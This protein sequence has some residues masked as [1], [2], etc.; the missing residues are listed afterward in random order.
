MHLPKPLST[1]EE[2]F[3]AV[4]RENVHNIFKEYVK[5]KCKEDGEQMSNLSPSQMRGLVKL[6]KR[7]KELEIVILLTDK[8]GKLAVT[9]MES[10]L[11]M[12]AVHIQGDREVTVETSRDTQRKLNGHMSMW[13]KISG[14]G[15]NWQHYD[16]MR[17]TT[18]NQSC[19]VAP[20]SLMVKDHKPCAIDEL[21]K[22]RP[23][24]SGSEG[25][26]VHFGNIVSEHLEAIAEARKTTID[27]ISTEDFIN[28]IEGY[29]DEIERYGET[30]KEEA[31]EKGNTDMYRKRVAIV[32]ADAK[33]LYPSCEG[34]HSGRCVREAAMKSQLKVEGW[35]YIEAARYVAIGYDKFETREFGLDRVVPKRRFHKGRN[36]GVTGVEPLSGYIEDEEK[37]I[38]PRVEPTELEKR[39]LVAACLDI[40]VR[41]AFSLHLYQFGGRIYHQK[42]GGPIGMRL[43]GAAAKIVMGEW[44]ER[45]LNIME[46]N[47]VDVHLAAGFVDD[48][49]FLTT[50]IEK[51]WRW[52]M[53][54]KKL[55][56]KESWRTEDEEEDQEDNIRHSRVVQ[57]MMNSIYKNIQFEVEMAEDFVDRKLP[58]LDFKMWLEGEN[59]DG[60]EK[61]ER[62]DCKKRIMYSFYEKPMASPF[63]VMEK[64]ALPENSK[65]AT[66]AQELVRRMMNTSELLTQEERNEVIEKFIIRLKRSGYHE[67][68]IRNIVMS[69]LKG[70]ETKKEKAKLNDEKLHRSA[71]STQAKRH[72]KKVMGKSTW[73]RQKKAAIDGDSVK[74]GKR[75]ASGGIKK[76]ET[77]KTNNNRTP[78]TVLFVPRTPGG[79]LARRIRQS[80]TQM[81]QITGYRVKIVER[82]GVMIK[83]MVVKT[84]PWNDGS[85]G[86]PQCLI[87]RHENGGGDCSKRSVTYRTRCEVCHERNEKKGEA[88]EMIYVGESAR[89]GFERAEEHEADY[90]KA[91]EDSH[92]YKHWLTEHQTEEKPTFSM[93]ILKRHKSAFVRQI[94]EAV[95]IEMHSEKDTILNSKSEYNRC[96]LPRLNVKMGENDFHMERVTVQMTETDIEQAL[97]DN[98]NRKRENDQPEAAHQP[99]SKRRKTRTK[100]PQKMSPKKRTRKEAHSTSRPTKRQKLEAEEEEGISTASI[101]QK[102][103]NCDEI[104]EKEKF[105]NIS[106]PELKNG[107][108]LNENQVP[109]V[110]SLEGGE[111]TEEGNMNIKLYPLF[112]TV[113]KPGKIKEKN[114]RIQAK[115]KAHPTSKSQPDDQPPPPPAP[116]Q[117]KPGNL[118]LRKQ[119]KQVTQPNNKQPNLANYSKITA[120]FKPLTKNMNFSPTDQPLITSDQMK[121]DEPSQ[122]IKAASKF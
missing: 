6:R 69:G 65:N 90:T 58:T 108:K 83:R 60:K 4:R 107:G 77:E 7:I 94:S 117:V 3:I 54:E 118:V 39:K 18:I 17:E 19:S 50:I 86:R 110:D 43:A 81:E 16:R 116:T 5:E 78:L 59:D 24:V 112:D 42:D 56:F 40:A 14:M 106:N 80:E 31:E 67:D 96:Q 34:K 2:A 32:G 9:T 11:K 102:I 73:F 44:S 1:K 95:L 30:T 37:W 48:V 64:S 114:G 79:E 12:G 41:E 33:C 71:K 68:Q 27:V 76:V 25:M 82:G 52:N 38:F 57:D 119:R 115:N 111:K 121:N 63:S 120:H 103:N 23:V 93:K 51:G 70:Y 49:R 28:R 66:L 85:C 55:E 113:R 61:P 91:A 101:S 8:S 10:Y 100:K 89:T 36:P 22:T 53:K 21:P 74:S 87:C 75:V 13:L 35:N 99:K 47:K 109:L 29:N 105:E 97:E 26:D 88:K 72:W 98:N 20:L 62:D 84:N 104:K 46:N 122:P 45:L 15:E 92:M